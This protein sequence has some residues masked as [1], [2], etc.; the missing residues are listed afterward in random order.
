MTAVELGFVHRFVAP[1]PHD[2]RVT[3]LLL[4]GS[5]G[6]EDGLLSIGHQIL[7]AAALLS[8][9]G[10][11]LENGMPRF[12][13]RLAD[14]IVDVDDLKLRT[15]EL[16]GFIR[17]ASQQYG[18]DDSKIIAIGYSNGANIT[19]SLLLMYPHLLAGAVLFRPM[20]PF[21]PQ[22]VPDLTDVPVLL[23]SGR[24]D[25]IV[26]P[27]Q[28]AHLAEILDAAGARVSIHWHPGGHELGQDD[29]VAAQ[30]WISPGKAV[31]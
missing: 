4:H 24:D 3:L 17:D 15:H 22:H 5:G 26:S 21:R 7:P 23:A 18:L 10:K 1:P 30:N 13:R 12:S 31:A 6:N 27:L 14:G 2:L 28:S 29:L 16:A 11:V 19:G 25:R 20:V 8:P 9:R